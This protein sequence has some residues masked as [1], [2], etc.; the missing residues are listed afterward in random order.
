MFV[1]KQLTVQIRVLNNTQ[2]RTVGCSRGGTMGLLLRTCLTEVFIEVH[3]VRVIY[4]FARWATLTLRN[5]C[6]GAD[7]S[8]IAKR[9]CGC[10]E[11][12]DVA[13]EVPFEP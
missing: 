1:N 10:C 7:S 12:V 5:A 9:L 11:G 13:V 8:C 6:R 3:V 2:R 4:R